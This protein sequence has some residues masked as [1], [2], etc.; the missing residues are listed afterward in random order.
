MC[1]P[2]AQCLTPYCPLFQ[3]ELN[4]PRVQ[5]VRGKGVVVASSLQTAS[6]RS[7]AVPPFVR[8]RIRPSDELQPPE[9]TLACRSPE[10]IPCQIMV[11]CG[12]DLQTSL[13]RRTAPWSRKGR[14]PWAPRTVALVESTYTG[15]ARAKAVSTS[16]ARS[17]VWFVT[18]AAT[19]R[20]DLVQAH[21]RPREVVVRV[22]AAVPDLGP[23]VT[24]RIDVVR[25][26][27]G[28][29]HHPER[30]GRCDLYAP[31]LESDLPPDD[32]PTER[33]AI[34]RCPHCA[35]FR[36]VAR[37]FE[38]AGARSAASASRSRSRPSGRRSSTS[39][40][41]HVVAKAI[42]LAAVVAEGGGV[43]ASRH[44]AHRGQ[45]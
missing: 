16:S 31:H 19:G 44:L 11:A 29:S 23:W 22:C 33:F 10:E 3:V 12:H 20:R 13:D 32:E 7:W 37:C 36:A 5:R 43:T 28:V 2:T 9:V 8:G 40:G 35:A 25:G 30:P 39:G 26:V 15:G 14:E 17:H 6:G 4:K 18:P 41:P 27:D 38:T 34:Q 1:F 45:T 24:V 21:A 42:E